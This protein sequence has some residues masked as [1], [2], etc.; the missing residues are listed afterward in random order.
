MLVKDCLRKI[1]PACLALA[2]EM[3]D[4]G[5]GPAVVPYRPLCDPEDGF[6]EVERVGRISTLVADN[7]NDL[8][9]FA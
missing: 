9:R 3:K 5:R 4:A 6:R 1:V 8:P 2:G 7:P